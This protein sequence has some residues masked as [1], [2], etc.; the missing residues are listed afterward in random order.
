MA[1]LHLRKRILD[2]A[3][4][5]DSFAQFELAT[6]SDYGDNVEQDF[7]DAASWYAKAAAQGHHAAET[8]LL[9][10]HIL[11]QSKLR[12][13]GKVFARLQELA[14]TGDR[15][16]ENN[17]GLCFEFGYGTAQD[18][19]EAAVWYLRAAKGGLGTAQFNLGG[20]YFEGKGIEKNFATAVMWYTRAAEQRQEL[21]LIRLGWMYQKGLGVEAD[22]GRAVLLY[23]IA[24]KRGS[25]RAANHLAILFKK[26]IGVPKG[27][28]LAYELF[29][30]SVN[31]PENNEVVHNSTYSGTAYY[32]LGYMA[33]KGEGVKRSLRAARIWYRGAACGQSDCLEASVRLQPKIRKKKPSTSRRHAAINR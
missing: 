30:E 5:G 6:D 1:N 17:L 9:L 23:L 4:R 7:T 19:R 11:G 16:A 33:E 21:A 18:F 14:K 25:S 20:F 26:G 2:A 10:Q 24:Y 29:L 27:D 31:S 12:E 15:E 3:E 32:W 13:P 28:S 22:L 8:N